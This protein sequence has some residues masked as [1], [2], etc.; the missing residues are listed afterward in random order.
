MSTAAFD[1]LQGVTGGR[2]VPVAAAAPTETQSSSQQ[3]SGNQTVSMAAGKVDFYVS[4]IQ[5]LKD[6]GMVDEARVIAQRLNLSSS[7]V[8]KKDALFSMFEKQSDLARLAPADRSAKEWIPLK[9]RPLPP[10]GPQEELLDLR[11]FRAIAQP[12]DND[13]D[14]EMDMADRLAAIQRI[15]P[16]QFKTRYTA[17][18]KQGVKCVAYSADGRLCASGSLDTSI[19]IM[20]T[21]KMRTFGVV[22]SG[23]DQ[24]MEDLRPVIRTYYDHV[25]T[26]TSMAFH[27][28]EPKLF[29]GSVDKTIKIF[30]LA[31]GGVNKKAMASIT[32]VSPINVVCPHPCGDFVMVGTQHSVVRMYDINTSQCYSSYNQAIA[33]KNQITDVKA[34]ADGSIFASASLDGQVLLWDGVSNR[35]VNQLSNPHDTQAVY[36]CQWSRNNRYL[37]TTGGDH[38]IRLWDMRTGRQLLVYA[39]Q[40]RST[41]CSSLLATFCNNEEFIMVASSQ[42]E[43]ADMTLLD[44]RTGSI[45][46]ENFGIHQGPVRC[47]ATS[48]TDRTFL[49]GADD[50]KVRYVEMIN[51]GDDIG[52]EGGME[53]YED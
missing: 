47:L 19:K 45:I 31:R 17:Q 30:D 34:A 39:D 1:A 40:A 9:P 37:L 28:R 7:V 46:V 49:T 48:P 2:N 8:G 5:Q 36:S 51:A 25:G 33:H 29:T 14:A 18:H 20:D 26:V 53:D 3:Q 10:I 13:E 32:D 43:D 52:G 23:R 27:P 11:D 24:A 12:D 42:A 16:P 38:R 6:D 35:V 44:S 22:T 50:F 21:S 4:L 41:S 15:S